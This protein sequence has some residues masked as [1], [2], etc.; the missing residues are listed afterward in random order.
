ME[1]LLGGLR[2]CFWSLEVIFYF[3][4]DLFLDSESALLPL[5]ASLRSRECVGIPYLGERA[6]SMV[7]T[8]PILDSS[9]VILIFA[10]LDTYHVFYC[11]RMI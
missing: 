6:Q 11:S 7:C 8:L 3:F 5:V 2:E 4:V 1:F 10:F 9:F